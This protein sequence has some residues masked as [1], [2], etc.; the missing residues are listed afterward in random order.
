M[1]IGGRLE[2]ELVVMKTK[3]GVQRVARSVNGM[4]I[5]ERPPKQ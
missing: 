5:R 2:V 4:L 3:I 1:E